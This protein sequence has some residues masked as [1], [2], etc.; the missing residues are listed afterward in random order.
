MLNQK[1][2]DKVL[3]LD[4]ETTSQ[5]PTLADVPTRMR[6]LFKKRFEKEIKEKVKDIENPIT[7]DNIT[8]KYN[9][10][11]HNA[12]AAEEIY[13]QKA[14]L[15]AEFN[16]IICISAGVIDTT[17][18]ENYKL[19]VFSF[20]SEDEK[21]LLQNFI[22]KIKAIRFYQFKEDGK[23]RQD[24]DNQFAFCAHN[25]MIFDFPVIAKRLIYNGLELPFIFDYGEKKPW[26]VTWFIDT[27]NIWK[28]GVFDGNVSLDM[29]AGA[30][31]VESSK[32]L[33]SGDK[34]KDV[35]WLLKDLKGIQEYC[36][37]DILTLARI[38]LKMKNIHVPLNK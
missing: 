18:P 10:E 4:I 33:M 26:D 12:L 23:T 28:W 6:E 25:G 5:Y 14:P 29:L 31:D 15:F 8:Y 1:P 19:K 21:V 24:A 9:D 27:K 17:D 35:Y 34:V 11:Q 37:F 7:S 16:K 36:E 22:T 13:N 20:C 32:T 38:Y 2:I 30:F 3:F